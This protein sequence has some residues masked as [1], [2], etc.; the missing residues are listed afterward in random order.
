[1]RSLKRFLKL[2]LDQLWKFVDEPKRVVVPS[3]WKLPPRSIVSFSLSA[4]TETSWVPVRRVASWLIRAPFSM[5]ERALWFRYRT[6]TEP[7]IE[8]SFWPL[9]LDWAQ[10]STRLLSRPRL[11]SR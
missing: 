4:V 9:A 3:V 8:A 11:P 7:A 6:M 5:V 10:E 1:M 2:S